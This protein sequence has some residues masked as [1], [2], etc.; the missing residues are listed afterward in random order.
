[1]D[2]QLICTEHSEQGL[3]FRAG[4]NEPKKCYATIKTDKNLNIS[5]DSRPICT[6]LSEQ[7]SFSRATQNRVQE[8]PCYDQN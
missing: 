8:V 6:E 5:A 4:K 3:F 7:G 1:M 2:Y